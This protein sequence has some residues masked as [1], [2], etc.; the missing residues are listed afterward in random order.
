MKP[1]VYKPCLQFGTALK[2]N[3]KGENTNVNIDVFSIIT[4]TKCLIFDKA[5]IS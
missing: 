3:N 4:I 2:V 5:K 1:V